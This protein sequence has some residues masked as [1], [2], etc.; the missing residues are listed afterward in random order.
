[1]ELVSHSG[2]LNA[3][4]TLNLSPA[5]REARGF[6]ATTA[7]SLTDASDADTAMPDA[8]ETAAV[9]SAGF[10]FSANPIHWF[11]SRRGG[12]STIL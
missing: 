4:L 10:Y 3:L 12:G 7:R 8:L 5:A 11:G 9:S 6:A 1:V 2:Q